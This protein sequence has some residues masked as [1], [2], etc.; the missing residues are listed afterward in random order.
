MSG[1][2]PHV[3][4]IGAGVFGGWTAWYA[5]LAG[6]RVT[7]VDAYA[8]GHS[9][10]SSG[11]ETR[12]IREDYGTRLPYMNLAIQA[13]ELWR[14]WQDQWN[15][16]L[17]TKTGRLLLASPK[18]AK[19]CL[20]ARDRLEAAGVPSEILPSQELVKRWPQIHMDGIELGLYNPTAGLLRAREACRVVAQ[21]FRTA[22]GSLRLAKAQPGK[23]KQAKLETLSL[24]DGTHLNADIFVFACGPWLPKLFPQVLGR[25]L[26]PVRRDVFFVGPPAGDPRF[27][28]PELPVWGFRGPSEEP[29]FAT[30][31]GFPS[32]EGRGMKLCPMDERNDID[33]DMDGRHVNAY[34]TKRVRD[35]L[36]YRFPLLADQ[37]IIETR[38]CQV[39]DSVNGDFLV[40]RHPGWP[41][42]WMVGGGAG[43]GYKHGPALG[44]YVAARLL[45]QDRDT[46]L[47]ALFTLKNQDL[48]VYK[49]D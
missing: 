38:V 31:Y 18:G 25:K 32:F 49:R 26:R 46:S 7:L 30:Y 20:S 3:V 12:L 28:V 2:K 34:Q 8:P 48:D 35:F 17:F 4:V 27:S 6:A 44:R 45:E 9:R 16:T 24:S 15:T 14:H 43:H 5:Q 19:T 37:P 40:D 21:R 10:S 42:V 11:G 22:G 23:V 47:D 1:P 36:A 29:R 13:M 33:P 39:T 41:N